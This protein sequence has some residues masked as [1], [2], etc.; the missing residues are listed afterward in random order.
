MTL[1]GRSGIAAVVLALFAALLIPSVL[2]ASDTPPQTLH[3]VGDHWTAWDPPPVPPDTPDA[4]V[5]IVVPGDTLW[6]I[7]GKYLGNSYLWPQIWEKNTY[8]L[9]AHWI[10][11]G[12]PIT[13]GAQVAPVEQLAEQDLGGAAATAGNTNPEGTPIEERPPLAINTKVVPLAPLGTEDDIYC[14]GYVGDPDEQFGYHIV[15]SEYNGM[16]PQLNG[17]AGGGYGSTG[18]VFGA[19]TVKYNL[20][21]G[22]IVY[23]DGGMAA[24]LTPGVVYTIVR[25]LDLLKNP[26]TRQVVGRLYQYQGRLRLLTVQ[27]Q[28]AIAEIVQACDSIIDG[29]GLK[30]FVPEPVPLGRRTGLRPPNV[31]VS[32][33]ALADD[34]VILR[35][36]DDLVSLGEDHVVFV[37]LGADSGA[38]PGDLYTIYR[39]NAPGK[40]PV[41]L[42]ELAVLSVASRGAVARIVTSRYPIYVG[43][44]LEPK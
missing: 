1:R 34:P 43:D 20:T 30:P 15:G 41:V 24:G 9:D 36:K 25:P 6:A 37:N 27:D 4:Q 10:Y 40:P 32:T 39:R 26:D 8:I 16:S 12:D 22:D 11:P 17:A 31:P 29:A 33:E 23:V 19:D 28:L 18:T 7:A 13:V 21:I 38:A 14:S 2:S 35:A 44:K 3:K 5:H 42:G